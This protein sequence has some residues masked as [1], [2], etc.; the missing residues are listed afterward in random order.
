MHFS[1]LDNILN[2]IDSKCNNRKR[3]VV[4]KAIQQQVFKEGH[5]GL[6]GGHFSGKHMYNALARHWWWKH[7]YSDC[8]KYC[9]SCPKCAIV[10]GVG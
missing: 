6:T 7:I 9:K 10:S 3:V 5:S 2:Y 8:V 4:L 1:L